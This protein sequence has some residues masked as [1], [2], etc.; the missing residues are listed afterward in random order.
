MRE[1]SVKI[2]FFIEHGEK[3]M[4]TKGTISGTD[5]CSREER[6]MVRIPR[7][8]IRTFMQMELKVNR[9]DFDW[10]IRCHN[11]AVDDCPAKEYP[12]RPLPIPPE[13]IDN[14]QMR[15]GKVMTGILPPTLKTIVKTYYQAPVNS[16]Q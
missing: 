2:N 5:V 1:L 10:L 6:R 4:N 16:Q 8:M 15:L 13:Y 14:L 11:C 9:D 3:V 7:T 12:P